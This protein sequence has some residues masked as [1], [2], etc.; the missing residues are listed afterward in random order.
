MARTPGARARGYVTVNPSKAIFPPGAPVGPYPGS[1]GPLAPI[2]LSR[3]AVSG[4]AQEGQILTAT[5]G[6][7]LGSP[8]G[9]SYLWYRGGVAIAG[10]VNSTRT[11]TA[12]D[13]GAVM[14]CVVTAT[15]AGGSTAATSSGTVAVIAAA[16]PV[17][18]NSV[19]PVVTGNALVGSV[20]TTG[21]GTWSG[22]PTGY[23]YAWRRDGVDISGASNA[24]YT[25]VTADAGHSITC[26]V[27]A[28]NTGGTAGATSN[29]VA[30]SAMPTVTI[31]AAQSKSEGNSG[32]SLYTY[33]VTRSTAIGA[34][35][36]PWSF[37]AGGTDATDYTG[38]TLPAGG[39]VSMAD[40]VAAGTIV[41]SVNGDTVVE[42]DETFTVLISTPAGY[43]AGAATSATGTILN[44]DTGSSLVDYMAADGST[45]AFYG[46]AT[47]PNAVYDATANKTFAAWERWDGIQRVCQ[48]DTYDHAAQA[49]AGSAV[50]GTSVLRNDDHGCPALAVSPAGYLF[51]FFG[52]HSNKM[53][54][55]ISQNSRDAS[56]WKAIGDLGAT[57]TY[58]HPVFVGTDLHFFARSE[59]G[60]SNKM[61]LVHYLAPTVTGNSPVFG[62]EETLVDYGVDTRFYIGN[63]KLGP[64]G[65][66]WIVGTRG[67]YGDDYRRDIY[68]YRY[69]P[70]NGDVANMDG[71][72]V[73][74]IASRPISLATA[75][76]SY[77]VVTTDATTNVNPAS[78]ANIPQICW[79]SAGNLHLI[80]GDGSTATNTI[81]YHS[82][83][84]AAGGALSAPTPIALQQNRY[85]GYGIRA[86]GTG[87]EVLASISPDGTRGGTIYQYTRPSG[88]AWS[89]GQLVRAPATGYP[90]DEPMAV[91]N[92]TDELSWMFA[93]VAGGGA[94]SNSSVSSDD[95]AGF[96]RVFGWGSGG[97]KQRSPDPQLA[98]NRTSVKAG[99]AV[100]DLVALITSRQPREA[101]SITDA[102]G[103]FAISG[104]K[105]V[106]AASL[107]PGTY[108]I[109]ITSVFRGYTASANFNLTVAAAVDVTDI[110]LA[111][112]DLL[113]GSGQTLLDTSGH[114]LNGFLGI[115]TSETATDMIRVATGLQNNS[116][117]Q[118]GTTFPYQPV[119][120]QPAMH[121][122]AAVQLLTSTGGGIIVARRN[123][124]LNQQVFGFDILTGRLRWTNYDKTGSAVAA[125]NPTATLAVN[126]WALVEA[127][128]SGTSVILRQDGVD[129]YSATLSTAM[130]PANSA[131]LS[132][133]SVIGAAGTLGT[134][135]RGSIGCV[136][137]YPRPLGTSEAAAARTVI[138]N[139]MAARGVTLP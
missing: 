35:L 76:A 116:A 75:Q 64:D 41:I 14:T 2:N 73:T 54:V 49:W 139:L 43:V 85:N 113:E 27:Y 117:G 23:A 17:P 121:V 74:P 77:R 106:V 84:A 105:V 112:Y 101:L 12:A 111:R 70:A 28:T 44:D 24:T 8:T 90:L 47:N 6:V 33:T 122:L 62:A 132:I 136:H 108:P 92:G 98:L 55:R 88:G 15:N 127:E 83:R 103:K 115:S 79:D 58:P 25:L 34:A 91:F 59:I 87:L 63:T 93:E 135:L 130:V 26:R 94:S 52:P 42:G 13:I 51:A 78:S 131:D 96:Q 9:Y 48:V 99:L 68:L 39:N 128:V 100:G 61:T 119:M 95:N 31:S 29:A 67:N 109:T 16:V 66:I 37:T 21:N 40:G 114:G 53:R 45:F 18:V 60:A 133:G 134:S 20:L 4:T 36:V 81:I 19:A 120:N 138:K 57:L 137:A 5:A 110:A 89:T 56:S 11:L 46:I 22:S 38:G 86:S 123:G 104:R 129:I 72:V 71:S 1:G 102:S 3:P 125:L 107:T 50:A 126:Q 97:Y 10:S 32:A 69:N 124:F 65:F 7:W 118:L 82:I 30:A 80:W